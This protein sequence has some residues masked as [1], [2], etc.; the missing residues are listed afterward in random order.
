MSFSHPGKTHKEDPTKYLTI[1][2]AYKDTNGL[3]LVSVMQKAAPQDGEFMTIMMKYMNT[4]MSIKP[5]LNSKLYNGIVIFFYLEMQNKAK[6]LNKSSQYFIELAKTS[7][8]YREDQVDLLA[9]GMRDLSLPKPELKSFEELKQSPKVT[10]EAEDLERVESLFQNL[11]GRTGH[12]FF[13]PKTTADGADE[14]RDGYIEKSFFQDRTRLNAIEAVNLSLYDIKKYPQMSAIHINIVFKDEKIAIQF[15]DTFAKDPNIKMA[16]TG[17]K[18][19]AFTS[20]QSMELA[21]NKFVEE[22]IISK[23]NSEELLLKMRVF[24][25]GRN[26]LSKNVKQES[27]IQAPGGPR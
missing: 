8:I 16:D 13:K 19:C 10:Q 5:P 1:A 2:D 24:L 3:G 26:L 23:S 27:F 22:N 12:K 25:E 6:E 4:V 11:L 15:R 21:F 14:V 18:A 9:R 17:T 7:S 20:F